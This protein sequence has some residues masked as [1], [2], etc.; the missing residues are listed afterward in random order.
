MQYS[1]SGIIHFIQFVFRRTIKNIKY[2]TK[3]FSCFAGEE[4]AND[5]T[6]KKLEDA[7][8]EESDTTNELEDN[9][10]EEQD[11]DKE[12]EENNE[13]DE[14]EESDEEGKEDENSKKNDLQLQFVIFLQYNTQLL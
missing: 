1:V 8:Q 4:T 7:P 2:R 12:D 11:E 13:K 5:E 9:A 14:I 10:E 6:P 3:L